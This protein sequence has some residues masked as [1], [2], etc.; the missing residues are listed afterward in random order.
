MAVTLVEL[1]WYL[2]IDHATNTLKKK[3]GTS[4]EC[5]MQGQWTRMMCTGSI[6]SLVSNNHTVIAVAIYGGICKWGP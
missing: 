3:D 1:C 5:D 4:V 6:G 2:N